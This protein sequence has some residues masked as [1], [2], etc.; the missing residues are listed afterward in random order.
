MALKVNPNLVRSLN[1][2]I[3]RLCASI[4]SNNDKY[5]FFRCR[6]HSGENNEI[7]LALLASNR[8]GN[9]AC[10]EVDYHEE[11]DTVYYGN[12]WVLADEKEFKEALH[13][14]IERLMAIKN[15]VS[16]LYFDFNS[17]TDL[18]AGKALYDEQEEGA[19]KIFLS[20]VGNSFGNLNL[21]EANTVCQKSPLLAVDW[22]FKPE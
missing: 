2:Y 5:A 22:H 9:Y 21:C 4:E 13:A 6:V 7:C 3:K 15:P 8:S 19:I 18:K 1:P 12:G 16:E 11:Q 10:L 14:L 17:Y 20:I